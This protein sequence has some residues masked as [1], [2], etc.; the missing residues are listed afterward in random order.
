MK[1]Q[2]IVIT[3][4][5]AQGRAFIERLEGCDSSGFL[6]EPLLSI[7]PMPVSL[8]NPDLYDGVIVTSVHGADIFHLA[9]PAWLGKPFYCVGGSVAAALKGK[10]VKNI[11]L[12]ASVAI[13]LVQEVG[14]LCRSD[15][16]RI[17]YLRGRDVAFD[18]KSTLTEANI[19]VD[20]LVCY[21]AL[22]VEKFS[23]TFL[24]SL[25]NSEISAITFFSKRTATV[26]LECVRISNVQNN[27]KDIK[28]L[29]IS[30]GVLDYLHSVFGRNIV[31]SDTPD[32][33]GMLC[34]IRPFL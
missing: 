31:V 10:G 11:C 24:R 30:D 28:A 22:S 26:F 18:V 23:D 32:A 27:L 6:L 20:E 25:E 7:R 34:I 14:A 3:R 12:I 15:N 9:D 4:P 29:C 21:E 1:S 16:S 8:P 5:E 17:L 2:K 33:N 19:R 13:A